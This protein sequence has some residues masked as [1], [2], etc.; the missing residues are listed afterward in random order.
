MLVTV[1]VCMLAGGEGRRMG[2]RD[3]GLVD[4][5]GA[6]LAQSVLQRLSPQATE[7]HISANRH[8]QAYAELWRQWGPAAE[9]AEA[10]D[11]VA[12]AALV[13]GAHGAAGT[14][15]TPGAGAPVFADAPDLPPCSGPLAGMLTALRRMRQ[16]GKDWV[17]FVPCDSPRLPA[18]LIERLLAAALAADADVVVPQTL[19]GPD[20]PRLHWVCALVH[21]RTLPS[22][23]AHFAEGE[24]K[25]SRW[26]STL[27][28]RSVFFEDSDAFANINHM[29]TPHASR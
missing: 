14:H 10:A 23:E 12:A 21:T 8:A 18:D 29:E 20:T 22:L 6:P 11:G 13:P 26:M 24:R 27:S 25:V 1:S 17:Q 4:W 2:G 7:L 28:W 9:V 3:K 16:P 19:D 15:G 5:R